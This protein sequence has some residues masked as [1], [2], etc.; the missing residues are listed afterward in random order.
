M[1]F[2][3]RFFFVLQGKRYSQ[4][5]WKD[6]IE[7]RIKSFSLDYTIVS[8]TRKKSKYLGANLYFE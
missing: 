2:R 4:E 5:H 7:L 6:L 8:L 1:R 3:F